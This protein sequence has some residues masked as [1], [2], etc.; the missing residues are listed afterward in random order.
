MENLTHTLVGAT[1]YR[2]W[3]ERYVPGTLPLWLIGANLPDIDIVSRFWGRAANLE[4]HRGLSHSL[5]GVLFFSLALATIWWFWQRRS[6]RQLEWQ[7]LFIASLV[8]LSTHPLLDALNN[9]GVRPLLPFDNSWFYGDLVFIVDPWFWLILGGGLFLQ[10]GSELN[11]KLLY[12]LLGLVTSAL[13]LFVDLVS[14]PAK[15]LWLVGLAVLVACRLKL[16]EPISPGRACQAA[17]FI[18]LG[19]LVLLYGLQRASLADAERYLRAQAPEP[20]SKFSVSPSLSNPL[21]W[22]VLAESP[23]FFD[24]GAVRVGRPPA[25][26]LV[27]VPVSRDHPAVLKALATQEGKAMARFSRYL[28]ADVEPAPGGRLVILRDGRFSR[29]SYTGFSVFKIFVPDEK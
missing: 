1:L 17:L 11:E 2:S 6:G 9:Y 28:L 10:S 5:L 8:A 20:I 29:Y 15:V 16:S 21:R 18:L 23:H 3:F 27:S 7:R 26:P 14:V 12:C 4:H 19:Y 25:M 13:I 22:E 24:Y